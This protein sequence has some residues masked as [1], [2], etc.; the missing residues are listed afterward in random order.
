MEERLKGGGRKEGS[1]M[2]LYP[3]TSRIFYIHVQTVCFVPRETSF[4]KYLVINTEK[5]K[6]EKKEKKRSVVT[7]YYTAKL[8]EAR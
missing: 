2:H 4:R 6:E 3:F 7:S 8:R 1:K 5:L